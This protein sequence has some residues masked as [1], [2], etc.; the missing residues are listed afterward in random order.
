MSPDTN[1]STSATVKSTAPTK[2]SGPAFARRGPWV[3]YGLSV[4]VAIA[5]ILV[6]WAAIPWLGQHAP[7]APLMFVIIAAGYLCGPG[8]S[9]VATVVGG[10]LIDYLFLG[11]PHTLLINN[12]ASDN[13]RLVIFL[14]IGSTIS[15]ISGKWHRAAAELADREF[16]LRVLLDRMPV[17]L[18]S[19]DANLLLTSSSSA[20]VHYLF[21]KAAETLG[22]G[23][24]PAGPGFF[25][26]DA[27]QFL[28]IAAQRRALAGEAVSYELSCG[29]RHFQVHVEPLRGAAG[30]ISGT[31]GMAWDITEQHRAEHLAREYQTDLEARVSLRTDELA[32]ANLVLMQQI[33]ERKRA[34]RELREVSQHARCILWHGEV[35]IPDSPDAPVDDRGLS[36]NIRV[37]DEQS[38][39]QI[40]PL[41]VPH[42]ETYIESFQR[43]RNAGDE[44]ATHQRAKDAILGGADGYSGE[45]RCCDRN[46]VERWLL[47][48]VSIQRRGAGRWYLV[49]VC[50]DVTE[51]KAAQAQRELLLI[52]RA[53]RAE[54]EAQS[55]AKDQFL[56]VLS[57]EL[58]TPMTPVL[59]CIS[60]MEADERLPEDIRSQVRMI[61]RN[62]ELEARLIDDLLD[63]TR[64]STGKLELAVREIDA[65]SPLMHAR[66][67]CMPD[68]LAKRLRVE[69]HATAERSFVRADGTRLQQVFWN[70][71]RNAVKF[72]PEGGLITVRTGNDSAGRL[73]VEI[74]DTG[75]GID[76]EVL[77]RIFNAFEQGGRETTRKFGG[78]GLGLAISKALVE[79]H[80]GEI[81]VASD[82]PGR[83]ARF[84][85]SLA[86]IDAVLPECA[87]VPAH[88]GEVTPLRILL[89][90]DHGDTRRATARLLRLMGHDVSTADCVAAGLQAAES[91]LEQDENRFNGGSSDLPSPFDLIISDIG[92]PDGSGHDL[93]RQLKSRYRLRGIAL[94][95]YGME[96]DIRNSHDAGFDM[97]LTKPVP[98]E[99]LE[100]AIRQMAEKVVRA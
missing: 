36:W 68:V 73:I 18:W 45:F 75:V 81:G 13:V 34:E 9:M 100:G 61:R 6:V 35:F 77:P 12:S 21:D 85:V 38:A 58:R 82:G 7:F 2:L 54:A 48:A 42:G 15:W 16:K 95:G 22:S 67:V 98:I 40:L 62:I 20:A 19:T 90:E 57:H 56:A 46:G 93:M 89:V 30:A 91:R 79:L 96:Q 1:S 65:H 99:Q 44:A 97:H 52:E 8:P 72:T 69:L 49:G 39:Q 4:L 88:G 87:N 3:R 84:T 86:T 10:L 76:P 60:A 47:E 29:E 17:L 31:F 66:D 92:L 71:I 64:V 55:L 24:A 23:H 70:L 78:L 50:T 25:Q 32:R 28:P 51:R 53:G 59:M 11:K 83:G 41:D 37:S 33:A 27:P 43:S 5:S 94:S 80:G 14:A 26:I 74:N 63:L